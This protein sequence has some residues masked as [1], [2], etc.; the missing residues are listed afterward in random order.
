MSTAEQRAKIS[1]VDDEPVGDRP[2]QRLVEAR[3]HRQGRKV[4]TS[5][6]EIG[7]FVRKVVNG[8]MEYLLKR[9]LVGS[10]KGSGVSVS[11]RALKAAAPPPPPPQGD[12]SLSS[13]DGGVVALSEPVKGNDDAGPIQSTSI[14]I[15][16]FARTVTET[17]DS[18]TEDSD[19][20]DTES[21]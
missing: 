5:R 21:A 2:S 15:G 18:T 12:A 13:S 6:F 8:R 14:E 7:F 1:P 19:S 3:S 4:K 10:A 16:A 20:D 11:P 9:L 17:S